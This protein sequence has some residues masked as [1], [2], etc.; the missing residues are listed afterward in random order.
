MAQLTPSVPRVSF[1]S[2]GSQRKVTSTFSKSGKENIKAHTPS[3]TKVITASSTQPKPVAKPV[4]KSLP[5][6]ARTS[7]DAD[8]AALL[9]TIAK[10]RGLSIRLFSIL[11]LSLV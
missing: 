8:T 5:L 10:Q 11:Q 1:T 9:A 2:K 4:K 6:Q 3:V 7:S